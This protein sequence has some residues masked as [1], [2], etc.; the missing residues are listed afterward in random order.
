MLD[1][2]GW[3]RA[4]LLD[5]LAAKLTRKP[6]PLPH[7][8]CQGFPRDTFGH[9]EREPVRNVIGDRRAVA[10]ARCQDEGSK[11]H[12]LYADG[13]DRRSEFGDTFLY[14]RALDPMRSQWPEMLAHLAQSGD[15]CSRGTGDYRSTL[16]LNAHRAAWWNVDW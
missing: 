8:A 1:M 7:L 5:R 12:G 16:R 11:G 9:Q 6:Q 13:C 2:L 15:S 14:R 3:H 4:K 10:L